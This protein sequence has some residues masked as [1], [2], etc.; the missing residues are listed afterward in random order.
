[1]FQYLEFTTDESVADVELTAKNLVTRYPQIKSFDYVAIVE[2]TIAFGKEVER[3]IPEE[4]YQCLFTLGRRLKGRLH[5]DLRNQPMTAAALAP[6]AL[7]FVDALEYFSR[8]LFPGCYKDGIYFHSEESVLTEFEATYSKIK[9]GNSGVM[10]YAMAEAKAHPLVVPSLQPRANLVLSLA[11]YLSLENQGGEFQLPVK[12]LANW[13]SEGYNRISSMEI[14]R[15]NTV[16]EKRGYLATDGSY[17]F[18]GEKAKNFKLNP[19]AIKLD[20]LPTCEEMLL[21]KN[22]KKT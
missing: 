17:S 3:H 12:L 16:L 4:S 2:D 6:F 8:G 10:D 7:V 15:I 13:L 19:G 9:Y 5:R 11:Y 14:S 1:M 18:T 22:A 20:E 21:T